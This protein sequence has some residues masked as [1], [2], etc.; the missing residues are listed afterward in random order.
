MDCQLLFPDHS[1]I[2]FM[3]DLFKNH[4][5]QTKGILSIE[6]CQNAPFCNIPKGE[7]G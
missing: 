6:P 4:G 5:I 3:S 2:Y 7:N 1:I